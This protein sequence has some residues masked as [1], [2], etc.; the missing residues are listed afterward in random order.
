MGDKKMI[1][2]RWS[3]PIEDFTEEN[4]IILS[5]NT[6]NSECFNNNVTTA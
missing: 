6:G 5:L 2:F 4:S 3:I 1:I